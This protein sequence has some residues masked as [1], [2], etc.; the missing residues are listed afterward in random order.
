MNI[1]SEQ[2]DKQYRNNN[3]QQNGYNKITSPCFVYV[4]CLDS[5]L[6]LPVA[7][8]DSFGNG[9]QFFFEIGQCSSVF[10]QHFV[11]CSPQGIGLLYRVVFHFLRS[12][13]GR[14][15]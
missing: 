2:N 14:K 15:R 4:L 12:F 5:G 3:H 13:L 7:S 6:Q 10:P 11:T 9:I 8:V 1:Y